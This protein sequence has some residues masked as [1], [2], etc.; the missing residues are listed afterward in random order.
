MV[1]CGPSVGPMYENTVAVLKQ[2]FLLHFKEPGREETKPPVQ[3]WN[4]EPRASFCILAL[5][6]DTHK[7]CKL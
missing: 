6:F 3:S 1:L 4:A 7:Q 2:M 5:L